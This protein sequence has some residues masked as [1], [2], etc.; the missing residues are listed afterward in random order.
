MLHE[1]ENTNYSTINQ[2][3]HQITNDVQCKR[4]SFKMA[5]K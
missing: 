2:L 3:L 1:I 4:G 5:W